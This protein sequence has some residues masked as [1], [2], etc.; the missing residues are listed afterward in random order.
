[1]KLWRER[2]DDHWIAG[3][4]TLLSNANQELDLYEEG[5]EQAKE[6]LEIFKRLNN[7][8]A[9]GTSLKD[10]AWLLEHDKQLG[11]AEEAAYDALNLLLNEGDQFEVCQCRRLLGSIHH[12]KEETEKA[13]NHFEAALRI[14]SSFDWHTEQFWIHDALAR[15]FLDNN[16]FDDAHTHTERAKL[17]T[18]NDQY[19]LGRAMEMQAYV[20]KRGCKFGEAKSEALRAVD[21]FEKIGATKDVE[22]CRAI[23]RSIEVGVEELATS[24]GSDFNGKPKETVS[25]PTPTN[26]LFSAR[27]AE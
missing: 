25:L 26:S 12:S 19:C 22:D 11:A 1:M 7:K 2:E 16:R 6:S 20:L 10:L 15:L 17:Y 8:L 9:Q 13:I 4:L 23:L 5:I 3:T 24:S 21:V 27:G 14:A 18:V